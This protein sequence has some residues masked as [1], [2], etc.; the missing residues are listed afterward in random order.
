MS[1]S[2]SVHFG[3]LERHLI[4]SD[5]V[6]SYTVVRR[7]VIS[8]DG[9]VRIRARLK[10]GGLLELFEYVALNASEQI[11]RLKYSYHW[12]S[13]N[14]SLVRRWDMVPHHLQLPHAPHHV[15][16]PDGSVEGVADPPD[17]IEVLARIKMRFR[18]EEQE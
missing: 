2:I 12:Q 4:E 18:Q 14:G 8:T 15:H 9:K 3:R 5:V 6:S 17:A 13:A 1:Y 16:L 10:D 7:Q 11:A